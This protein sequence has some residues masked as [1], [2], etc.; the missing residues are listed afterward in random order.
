MSYGSEFNDPIDKKLGTTEQS[1]VDTDNHSYN[2]IPSLQDVL[3]VK[4]D[5][6]PMTPRKKVFAFSLPD[7]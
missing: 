1:S 4:K 2:D 5:K 6:N 7:T 3:K